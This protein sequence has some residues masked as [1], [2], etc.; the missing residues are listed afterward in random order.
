MIKGFLT[1]EEA[2]QLLNM[3]LSTLYSKV[4]RKEIPHIRINQRCIRFDQEE[5]IEW[6]NR[7]RVPVK[8][9]DAA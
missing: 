9:C 7:H 6:I 5:L 4:S 1:Y 2:S 3:S 8:N